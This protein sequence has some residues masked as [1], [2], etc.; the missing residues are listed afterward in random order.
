M[1]LPEGNGRRVVL[2]GPPAARMDLVC[3][4]FDI[5][6][7]R[8]TNGAGQAVVVVKLAPAQL[9][10]QLVCP[11]PALQWAQL[12]RGIQVDAETV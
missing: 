4:D 5:R 12:L 10:V 3:T 6:L 11:V 8:A 9:P 2:P 7:E 1:M